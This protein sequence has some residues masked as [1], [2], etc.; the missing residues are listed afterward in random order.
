MNKIMILKGGSP[1]LHKLGDI[2]RKE[3]DFIRLHSETEEYYVGSFEERL[4]FIDVKFKKEDCRLLTEEERK[5]LNGKWYG[6]NGMPLYRI[7]VDEQGNVVKG[8]CIMKKGTITKVTDQAG[9]D[10]SSNF[11]EL[12]VEFHED[13]EIGQNLILFTDDKY[14]T[15]SKVVNVKIIE[16][17]YIIYTRNSIYYIEVLK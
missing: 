6:I 3:D 4:G 15:T 16:N 8:K 10:K 5:D 14:I 7:Y 13:I 11:I 1:A 2:S 12:N 17:T 9:E